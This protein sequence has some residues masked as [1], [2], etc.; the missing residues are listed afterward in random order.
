MKRGNMAQYSE[1]LIRVGIVNAL[2]GG[3][4]HYR[5]SRG[6]QISH[7]EPNKASRLKSISW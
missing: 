6:Q 4:P 2:P 5:E 3:C 7:L 1:R